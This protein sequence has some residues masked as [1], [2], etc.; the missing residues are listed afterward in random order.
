MFSRTVAEKRK[1][2]WEMTPI[3]RRSER[4]LH[5]TDVGAVESHAAGGDVV[6]A[7]DQGG[8][9]GLARARMADERD[10]LSRLDLE[11]DLMQDVAVVQVLEADV[12]EPEPPAA[13]RKLRRARPV[14]DLYRL[15]HDLEDALT[16]RRRTLRLADP[17][18]ERAQR[19]D[20]HPE[21]EVEGDEPTDGE[22]STRDHARADEQ[23]RGLREHRH[24]RDQR[25]VGSTLP[26]C[27]H[28][29]VEHRLRARAELL[30]L[31]GFLR[32][33]LDDVDAD[34]VLLGDRGDVRQ[35]LLNVA[36]CRVR[37]VAVPIS[38]HDDHGSDRERDQGQLPF[39]EEEDRRDRQHRQGVLEEEDEPVAE[40]EAN[41]LEIHGC[42]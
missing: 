26:V 4:E 28:R 27:A 16:G 8:E 34:D 25:D 42:S 24:P 41:A 2:S 9:R 36:Q 31:L 30:F 35:L 12:L 19:H 32:E 3:S 21:I 23:N 10:R 15:V 37:D 6:E 1:G 7:R 5:V 22:L 39:E 17:H 20:Q 29:L 18:A 38:E 33:R 14:S 13:R 11:L 40:E